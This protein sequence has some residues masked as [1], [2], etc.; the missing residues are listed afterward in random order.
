MAS[1]TTHERHYRYYD[2]C[3]LKRTLSPSEYQ[4]DFRG[5][6]HISLDNA[7]RLA[8]E[9]A[10]L[11]FIGQETD[12]PVPRVIHAGEHSDGSY[13][14]WTELVPGVPLKEIPLSDQHTVIEQIERYKSTLQGLR[15]S[16][17]GGPTGIVCPPPVAKQL[18]R[19]E[20][21]ITKHSPAKE[22]VFCHNDLSQSNV[23]VDPDTL[24]VNGIIDWEFAGFFPKCFD[25]PFYRSLKPPGA[26]IR[27][28]ADT[29]ELEQFF[30]VLSVP[31]IGL[32]RGPT[33]VLVSDILNGMEDS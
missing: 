2:N 18:Q 8:N 16:C 5:Q 24:E 10:T 30:S 26:Q 3:F 9:A 21:W 32:R 13:H 28:L 4:R 11:D 12:I 7:A 14:L 23:I 31:E 6:L 19:D 22:Y 1:W 15:S 20:M 29:C 17:I 33:A 27:S 25:V